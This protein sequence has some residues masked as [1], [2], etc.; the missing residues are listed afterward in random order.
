MFIALDILK[1][2]NASIEDSVDLLARLGMAVSDAFVA[3]WKSK[4]EYDVLRPVTYIKKLIDKTWEPIL[5][6]PP[7][8]EYPSGHSAQSGAAA[9]VLTQF[10]G[11]NFAFEDKTHVREK[12]PVRVYKSFWDA[13]NEAGI[14][15]LYGGIHF[16]AAVERGLDQGRCVGVAANALKTRRTA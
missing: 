6:T 7:F 3:C 16:R 2:R 8:P 4:F 10:F 13:A 11:E 14:S 1:S 15:R 5:I 9:A 12:L